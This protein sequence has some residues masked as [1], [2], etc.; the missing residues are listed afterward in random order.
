MPFLIKAP[1]FR[2]DHL[3]KG[4]LLG[5]SSP[6]CP[7]LILLGFLAHGD[8]DTQESMRG[9][10]DI[11]LVAK[12]LSKCHRGP[13]PVTS[14]HRVASPVLQVVW[15][16]SRAISHCRHDSSIL[17][18]ERGRGK[19]SALFPGGIEN[20]GR[21]AKVFHQRTDWTLPKRLK[22]HSPTMCLLSS[23]PLVRSTPTML[24]PSNAI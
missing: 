24:K 10:R 17:R 14:L 19:Y 20:A 5:P 1:E 7:T 8:G 22:R 23:T 12:L 6:V 9:G 3:K 4:C 15:I 16:D 2:L 11:S 13:L 18:P 21:S